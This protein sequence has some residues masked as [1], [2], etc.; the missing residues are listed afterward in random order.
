MAV[1][2][3]AASVAVPPAAGV[4]QGAFSSSRSRTLIMILRGESCLPV[5]FAGQTLVQRPHSV[6]AKP[7]SSDFQLRCSTSFAPN[8]SASAP[9]KSIGRSAPRTPGP[10][11]FER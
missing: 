5:R 11:V 7:S 8:C 4:I 3:S 6:Q 10:L 9:S 1:G 2:A